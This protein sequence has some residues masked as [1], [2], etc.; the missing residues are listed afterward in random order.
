M[1]LRGL[2]FGWSL[3]FLHGEDALHFESCF[4]RTKKN[5]I[6]KSC[7]DKKLESLGPDQQV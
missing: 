7:S 6:Y 3:V 2:S 1:S 5:L 4:K